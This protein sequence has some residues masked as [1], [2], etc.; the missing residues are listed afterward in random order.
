M[1]ILRKSH[2]TFYLCSVYHTPF[3]HSFFASA[4]LTRVDLPE[5]FV[6][7]TNISKL[8]L[9]CHTRLQMAA[10]KDINRNL[11]A[12]LGMLR[13]SGTKH[14][15]TGGGDKTDKA[16]S[17]HVQTSFRPRFDFDLLGIQDTQKLIWLDLTSSRKDKTRGPR[18]QLVCEPSGYGF[19]LP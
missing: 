13:E 18:A 14:S 9:T 4:L 15:P 10:C 5:Q 8:L 6:I 2:F 16:S 7:L 1:T 3:R 19:F 17:E 11:Q 12:V